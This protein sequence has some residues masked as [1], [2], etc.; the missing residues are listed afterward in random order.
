MFLTKKYF[1]PLVFFDQ[2]LFFGKFSFLVQIL[3]GS[4]IY[5]YRDFFLAYNFVLEQM[6][7]R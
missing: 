5:F 7:K 4:K 3:L 6:K 2:K 1:V